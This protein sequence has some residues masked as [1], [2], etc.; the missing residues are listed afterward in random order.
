MPEERLEI[1]NYSIDMT[2]ENFFITGQIM[3]TELI[4]EP[5]LKADIHK[6]K[7]KEV[8]LEHVVLEEEPNAMVGEVVD[9]WWD[10]KLNAPF[11][12]AMVYGETVVEKRVRQILVEDQSKP[13][14][15]RIYKGFSIGIIINR[16][17]KNTKA[18]ESFFP[19]ELSITEA[20]VCDECT[21][22]SV[23]VYSNMSEKKDDTLAINLLKEQLLTTKTEMEKKNAEFS[24]A[25]K[26]MTEKLAEKDKTLNETVSTITKENEAY[27][28]SLQEKEAKI[29]ELAETTRQAKI[30]PYVHTLLEVGQFGKT[31][32]AKAKQALWSGF[33]ED[34][35]KEFSEYGLHLAKIFGQKLPAT[36]GNDFLSIETFSGVPKADP[37]VIKMD[38]K[39]ARKLLG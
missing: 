10:E 17:N 4:S 16:R 39:T 8:R 21:I 38:D 34:V 24:A 11:A 13:L 12:K 37:G 14:A 22:H 26:T 6:L 7:G 3:S 2:G 15:E 28:K 25:L 1:Q 32:V 9:V 23:T 33:S 18:I 5:V 30:A 20:P 35:L 36:G 29:A 19:R 27:K 31:D